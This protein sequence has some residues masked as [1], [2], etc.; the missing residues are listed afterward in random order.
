[1]AIPRAQLEAEI[2]QVLTDARHG[3]VIRNGKAVK[4]KY[5]HYLTAYQILH[6]LPPKTHT[7][8]IL[9]AKNSKVGKR[10]GT[11]VTAASRVGK[12]AGR[13][14]KCQCD[15]YIDAGGMWF[16]FEGTGLRVES[17]NRVVRL[18]RLKR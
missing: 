9:E 12:V 15:D 1:M 10:A 6:R 7:D 8:L 2:L 16:E 4:A 13:L 14:P 5:P 11:Y 3:K 17:G 18:Y